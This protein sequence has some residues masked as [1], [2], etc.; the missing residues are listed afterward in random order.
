M[1]RT[2]TGTLDKAISQDLIAALDHYLGKNG[3]VHALFDPQRKDSALTKIQTLI[4]Q[5]FGGKWVEIIP[6][7]RPCKS[8]K[9]IASVSRQAERW[10][11]GSAGPLEAYHT[12]V[13]IQTAV[14]KA[15]AEAE[16]KG[17]V[18]GRAYQN[19]VFLAV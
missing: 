12:Q 18:K 3:A 4:D 19:L 5:H 13:Q 6:M 7:V 9:S 16:E 17:T 2:L 1:I 15:R 8:G 11:Q 10:A 14:A